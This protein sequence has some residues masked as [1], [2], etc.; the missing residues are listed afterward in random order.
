MSAIEDIFPLGGLT[1]KDICDIFA[2]LMDPELLREMNKNFYE[3]CATTEF[4]FSVDPVTQT[5]KLR[6][7]YVAKS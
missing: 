3:N 5:P 2:G 4:E 1:A 7:K 6:Y